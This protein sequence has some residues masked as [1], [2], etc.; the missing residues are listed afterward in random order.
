MV[1]KCHPRA[2]GWTLVAF[3]GTSLLTFGLIVW[4]LYDVTPVR[5]CVLAKAG[6]VPRGDGCIQILQKLLEAKQYIVMTLLGIHGL[7]TLSVV[8]VAL[9][10]KI[11]ADGPGGFSVDVGADKTVI[12][13]G[14]AEA[15]IPTPPT[16]EHS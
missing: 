4:Q 6:D 5:W 2:L 13:A 1:N 12:S 10:V 8:V 15:T 9:G 7:T 3:A 11:T 16:V 14:S